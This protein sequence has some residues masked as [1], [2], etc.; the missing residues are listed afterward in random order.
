[1][2]PAV[3]RV[4][5]RL[6]WLHPRTDLPR[7]VA[8]ATPQATPLAQRA[9]RATAAAWLGRALVRRLPWLFPQTCLYWSLA[10]YYFLRQA[11]QPAVIHFG[12]RKQ[13]ED[14]T[15]HAWLTL[16]GQP[17]FDDP[18]R[19]GFVQTVSFPSDNPSS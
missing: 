6:R 15:S 3:L 4:L 7:L 10:G 2:L 13:D 18:E 17:Y 12:L 5:L 9:S 16:G 8:A 11:G 14:L 1:M 19:H